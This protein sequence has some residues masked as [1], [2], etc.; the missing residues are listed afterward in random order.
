MNPSD[1]DKLRALVGMGTDASEPEAQSEPQSPPAPKVQRAQPAPQM[2][3]PQPR[4]PLESASES[5]PQESQSIETELF[6]KVDEHAAIG[7]ILAQS[8]GNM[9]SIADT[10]SLLAKAEKLKSEAIE[11]MEAVL[12]DIDNQIALIESKIAAPEGLSVPEFGSISAAA[13]DLI[14]LRSELESLRGELGRINK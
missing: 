5:M 13:D 4:E 6:V 7:E 12:E 9:K 2:Q 1:I 3:R 10:I 14:D 11:R 8:K